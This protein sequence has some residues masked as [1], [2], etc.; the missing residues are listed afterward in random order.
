[1]NYFEIKNNQFEMKNLWRY[2]WLLVYFCLSQMVLIC[3]R[4]VLKSIG[5][6]M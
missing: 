4:K 3:A 5:F 1:M 6:S 2:F